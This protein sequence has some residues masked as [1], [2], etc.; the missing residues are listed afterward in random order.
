[1]KYFTEEE[2]KLL[3]KTVRERAELSLSKGQVTGV[4]DYMVISTL[5]Y[6][7]IRVSECAN[8]RCGD[9]KISYGKS[10]LFIRNGKG[11]KSRTIQIPNTLK[12]QLKSYLKWKK[13]RKEPTGLDDYL[14][15]GQRGPMKPS[16]IQ[17]IVKKY[18]K[19]LGLYEKG[20][21][22]HALR[23]SYA[24]AYYRKTKDLRGLQKQLGHSS[25]VNTQVYADVL[26]EDIK[27][28]VNLVW[29]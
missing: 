8:L 17:Q 19:K 9:V 10:E 23:H 16:A 5:I 14:F 1:M 15:L 24:V 29:N 22:V 2:I 7:G 13:Q 6:S 4:R 11:C 18:L 21:S 26:N 20:K 3:L 28:N 27:N 25:I 12:K